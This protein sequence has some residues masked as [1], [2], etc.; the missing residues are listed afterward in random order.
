MYKT[1]S[2]WHLVQIQEVLAAIAVVI[3]K[4]TVF[5]I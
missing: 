4:N 3:N 1:N 5:A 2:A